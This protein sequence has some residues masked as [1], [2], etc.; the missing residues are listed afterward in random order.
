MTVAESPAEKKNTQK[1]TSILLAISLIEGLVTFT[2]LL[3]I[4]TDPK[5]AIFL[6]YSTLRLIMMAGVVILL[7]VLVWLVIARNKAAGLIRTWVNRKHSP[8]LTNVAGWI[9]FILLWLV[10]WFPATRLGEF[11]DNFT[12]LQP[13]LIWFGL[14]LV[15]TYVALKYLCGEVNLEPLTQLFQHH[16]RGAAWVIGITCGAMAL[17]FL[18]PVVFTGS[19]NHKLYFPPSAPLSALQVFGSWVLISGVVGICPKKWGKTF[20]KTFWVII[21][22][23]LL[24]AAAALSWSQT[25]LACTDD[26]PG[27]YAPNGGCYP[28]VND[29]VYSIGSQ[30]I[31]LG[32]GIYHHW[33]TDKPLYM[34][35]LALGQEL[36]GEVIDDYLKF[37]IFI[38]ALAP[39]LLFL[40]GTKLANKT[41][42]FWLGILFCIIEINSINFYR[43]VGGVNVKLENPEVLTAFLLILFTLALYAW[44]SQ[45]ARVVWAM[46][47]GGILGL[48]TLTRFNAAFLIPPVVIAGLV[49]SWKKKKTLLANLAMFG[50]SF[51]LVFGPWFLLAQDEQGRNMYWTKIQN[52]LETRYGSTP[53]TVEP[54]SSGKS[55]ENAPLVVP[56]PQPTAAMPSQDSH[57]TYIEEKT[58]SSG[59]SDILLHFLNNGYSSLSILPLNLT[60]L[61]GNAQVDQPL[62]SFSTNVP[63]W[64]I[65]LTGENLI[66]LTLNLV[67]VLIGLAVVISKAGWAGI[68]PLLTQVGYHLG[69][70]LSKTSGSRYLEPVNW[71]FLLYFV[72]GIV[73]LTQ[74]AF[75]V[76]TVKNEDAASGPGT[77]KQD[78]SPNPH[79]DRWLILV[80]A[81]GLITA[82][83][84]LP[85]INNLPSQQPVESSVELTALAKEL[86]LKTGVSES[87]WYWF[88]AEPNA[89]VVQGK[90]Y[91]PRFYKSGFFASGN[92]SFELM[93]LGK[94][95]VIVSYLLNG[96]PQGH[97]TDGSDVILV[98]CKLGTDR[99][100]EANRII[101]QSYFVFQLDGEKATYLDA[102]AALRCDD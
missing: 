5:N 47:A 71:V 43:Q 63:I 58:A 102:D 94:D 44:L 86:S 90:A 60:L 13:V 51:C 53:S 46:A 62:W 2:A 88:I 101:M 1:V 36:F 35:F 32:Q 69:N 29:A 14:I 64:N 45:P 92:E 76:F 15:Q 57:L 42:G 85:V 11:A 87:A 28:T 54:S 25:N 17:F 50:L 99:L 82:G 8:G 30:Y 100:W 19:T 38:F 22:F 96:S 65:G 77:E 12:R 95:H 7:A 59:V 34:A 61:D 93:T 24:W 56:T 74:F 41:S 26:R 75:R 89:L 21:I 49:V 48:A 37:Q 91:H 55:G 16:K 84:V 52:V 40:L 79:S 18:L 6:G 67:L 27:P 70:A 98:G 20:A 23:V 97:F 73:A 72:V 9:F 31:S 3:A 81:I 78:T 39:A 4:P 68:A 10:T 80:V 83:L 66:V 33:M